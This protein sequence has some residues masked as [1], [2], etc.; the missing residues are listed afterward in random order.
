MKINKR[1]KKILHCLHI[2]LLHEYR[3]LFLSAVARQE[4]I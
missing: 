2:C 4:K 3:K 1:E